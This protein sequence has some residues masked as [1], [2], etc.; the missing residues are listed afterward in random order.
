MK[1]TTQFFFVPGMHCTSCAMVL[2]ALEDDVEGINSVKVDLKKL[3]MTV[4]YDEDKV[5][6]QQIIES[7]KKEGYEAEPIQLSRNSTIQI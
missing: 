6:V 5:S 1:N 7:A 3:E 2:E 4:E